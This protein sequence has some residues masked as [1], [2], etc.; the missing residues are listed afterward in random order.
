VTKQTEATREEAIT[1]AAM[2]FI[3]V[4]P[5][6]A[7][8]ERAGWDSEYTR[9]ILEVLA[10]TFGADVDDHDQAKEAIWAEIRAKDEEIRRP[11]LRAKPGQ[12][13]RVKL[14]HLASEHTAV[15]DSY[16]HFSFTHGSIYH[17]R[18]ISIERARKVYDPEE[19]AY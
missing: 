5:L 8:W 19:E 13:W 3:E 11:W 15:V 1:A 6:P 14:F 10:D 2:L 18:S 12:A 4:T 7:D 9:G 17:P 16:G